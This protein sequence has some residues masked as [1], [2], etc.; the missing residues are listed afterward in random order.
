MEQ[1]CRVLN[2]RTA[3]WLT[4]RRG[5]SAAAQTLDTVRYHQA[6]NAAA[7]KSRIKHRTRRVREL[8]AL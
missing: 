4:R 5:T 7:R 2:V 1:I 6:R 8:L 3:A